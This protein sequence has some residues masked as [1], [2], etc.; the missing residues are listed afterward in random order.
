MTTIP[1]RVHNTGITSDGFDHDAS[2]VRSSVHFDTVSS[3]SQLIPKRSV[4]NGD[5]SAA[6][7]QIGGFTYANSKLYG[8]SFA[9]GTGQKLF[10]ADGVTGGTWSNPA[11]MNITAAYVKAPVDY[12]GA[13][14]LFQS[15]SFDAYTYAAARRDA[16]ISGLNIGVSDAVVHSKDDV[17]YL[18]STN[19]IYKS[20]SVLGA[21]PVTAS[22][23]LTLPANFTITSIC[24]Y[25]NYLAIGCAPISGY[26]KS[27]VFLWDRDS[28][29]TT[30]SESIEW[31]YE[32]LQI[33]EQI[34]GVLIGISYAT[35]NTFGSKILF[36]AWSG[37]QPILFRTLL[38]TT[39]Y[40]VGDLVGYRQKVNNQLY[41]PLT[42]TLNGTKLQGIWRVGRPQ[43]GAPFTVSLDYLPNGDTGLT[44][45]TLNGFYILGDYA[46]ISYI[47]SAVYGLS[48]TDDQANYTTTSYIESI[49]N[50]RM[51]DGDFFQKKRLV[52]FGADFST[53]SSGQ[54][55]VAKYRV[56]GG[57]WKTIFTKT[58]TT[59][60]AETTDY[61]SNRDATGQFDQGNYYEFRLEST[62][63]AIIVGYVYEYGLVAQPQ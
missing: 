53:L 24:E 60:T 51:P 39:T 14:Y 45:G 54:Q 23:V 20:V 37:G 13:L 16:N 25:G 61:I 42:I 41:F 15:G 18:A 1:V 36:R 28:S 47:S 6:T 33:L 19:F 49:I 12:H 50:P 56:D 32:N 9:A 2:L 63:G 8:V 58:F 35:A 55:V 27:R 11:N 48:K 30:L 17:L 7:N 38:S 34:D 10:Y 3:P 22:L 52:R 44:S 5:T 62:G 31:G 59:P 29:V 43:A 4:E 46:F 26:G 40:V 21:N 57:S